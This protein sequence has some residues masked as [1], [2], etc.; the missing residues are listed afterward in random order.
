MKL[1][2]FFKRAWQVFLVN[3]LWLAFSLGII[4]GGAATCAAYYVWLKLVDNEDIDIPSTFVKGFKTNFK[5]GTLMWFI[6]VLTVAATVS[7]WRLIAQ[8]DAGLLPKIGAAA[9]TL[10]I[11]I[12]NIYVYPLIARYENTFKN[13]IKNA[14]AISLQYLY[15]TVM[16][17][18]FVALE[19]FVCSLNTKFLV[20]SVFFLPG[21]IV[22][23]VS[24]VVKKTFTAIEESV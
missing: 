17:C 23:T 20:I 19:I 21:L 16:T 1:K 14:F 8:N 4:T 15:G 2:N 24:T 3:F 11:G 12:L 18:I 13:T 7:F 6:T 10:I 9:Y 5:Q 22:Y